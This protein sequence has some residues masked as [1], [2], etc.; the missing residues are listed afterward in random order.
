[1]PASNQD[2]WARA[3]RGSLRCPECCRGALWWLPIEGV[4]ACD[5][6]G[7]QVEPGAVDDA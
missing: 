5:T 4:L 6:C 7:V 1:M 3:W 2:D